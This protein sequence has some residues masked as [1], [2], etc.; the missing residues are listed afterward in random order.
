MIT[1]YAEE[2]Q[3]R[4]SFIL[5]IPAEDVA[6][7]TEKAARTYAKQVRLPGFRPGKA[8]VEVVK[9]RFSDQIKQ[10][11]LEHLV[12][13]A[14]RDAIREKNLF[15]IGQP[16][17]DAL[18]LKEGEPLKFKL[19]LEVRPQITPK[20]YKG[21]KKPVEPTVATEA[22]VN[23]LLSRLREEH[24]TY[25]PIED[26]PAADGDFALCDIHGSFPMG[27][28][29]DFSA[30]KALIEIGGERTM[31]ELTAN[32]RNAEAGMSISF[33]KSFP[34]ELPDAE[35][36]GKTVLYSA[37]LVALKKKVLP[38]LDDELARTILTPKDGEPPANANVQFLRER[39]AASIESQKTTNLVE[40]QRRSV[41]DAL[42][43][44][45]P[46]EAPDSMIVSE[47]DSALREYARHLA[48][49]GVDLKTAEIDWNEMRKEAQPTAERRVKEYLL[50]D[51]VG[52]AEGI[53]VT[54]TELDAEIK[55]RAAQM[56]TSFTDLKG[57]LVKGEQLEG[58]REEM[59]INHV[60]DFILKEAVAA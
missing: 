27:D 37:T 22:E 7:A 40:R 19:D 18:E 25:D 14:V 56:G 41:L 35:F 20:D 59:R 10:E 8:P 48:R 46:I 33:Q 42:I 23:E 45:N 16:K 6:K 21:L 39:V 5:E 1:S 54:D 12:N 44:N 9:K 26:R 50:M 36:A 3:T 31:P 32:L 24:A 53:T 13:D 55:R 52:E 28:G 47:T 38:E 29:K 43:E 49:Q 34:A 58:M 15:P 57:Q 17:V 11:V 4:K 51:A 2:S 60:L 30:E